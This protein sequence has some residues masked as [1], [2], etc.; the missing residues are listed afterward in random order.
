MEIQD[1]VKRVKDEMIGHKYKHFKGNE[2]IVVDVGLNIE[3]NNIIVMVRDMKNPSITQCIS[4]AKFTSNVD[5]TKYPK[6]KQRMVFGK[7][8]TI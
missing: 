6:S 5:K 3:N 4:Y 7:I 1:K 8:G 2:Y